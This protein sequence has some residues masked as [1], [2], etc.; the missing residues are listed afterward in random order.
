MER[1]HD[2]A[3]AVLDLISRTEQRGVTLRL[4]AG[5][6]IC[7]CHRNRADLRFVGN[8]HVAVY[9]RHSLPVIRKG[10]GIFLLIEHEAITCLSFFHYIISKGKSLRS[11]FSRCIYRNR[12]YFLIAGVDIKHTTGK[13]V[14]AHSG[15]RIGLSYIDFSFCSFVGDIDLDGLGSPD[16]HGIYFGREN[17]GLY[18]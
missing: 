17:V 8:G 14:I 16:G 2:L 3:L 13:R 10:D 1:I 6:G 18:R 4:I 7:F 12:R 9:D 11:S 15:I 5:F